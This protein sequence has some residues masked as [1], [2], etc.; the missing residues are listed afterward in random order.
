M[1]VLNVC[2]IV[3]SEDKVQRF[4][5][6]NVLIKYMTLFYFYGF[7]CPRKKTTMHTTQTF[8]YNHKAIVISNTCA[9]CIEWSTNIITMLL[10]CIRTQYDTH[11]FNF[12]FKDGKKEKLT[13]TDNMK[14]K[15]GANTGHATL[16]ITAARLSDSG[17]YA[18]MAKSAIGSKK[19]ESTLKVTSKL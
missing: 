5:H 9:T 7:L 11:T 13:E 15:W 12:R 4:V 19:C 3:N 16:I 1:F 17:S 2:F 8:L 6:I 18:C 10:W 14:M